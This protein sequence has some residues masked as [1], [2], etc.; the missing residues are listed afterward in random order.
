MRLQFDRLK[1]ER[2][3]TLLEIMVALVVF[4][5][6][7]VIAMRTIP[8]STAKTSRSRNLTIA[9]NLAQEGIEELMG[10]PFNAADLTA[11]THADPDNPLRGHF[12]R[13]WTVTDATPVAGMK[14]ISV[15][16]SFP[17]ASA[18]SVAMLRT[19]KSSR[20]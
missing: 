19:F 10:E 3:A 15:S 2:G 11:G 8:E 5:I 12:D 17:T 14:L 4:G 20:Q 13:S 1:N 6:G 9:V 18:D 16:V 7:L